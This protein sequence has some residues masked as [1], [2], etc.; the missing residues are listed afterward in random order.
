MERNRRKISPAFTRTPI[1]MVAGQVKAGSKQSCQQIINLPAICKLVSG[2]TLMEVLIVLMVIGIIAAIAVPLYVSAA[3]TQLRTA[4][5]M[6]AS[7]LEYAKSMSI[8]TG[9]SHSIV[10]DTTAKSYSIKNSAG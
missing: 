8:S 7:D 1:C 4:A 3:S 5:N 2:F 6:I 10:F 9:Q